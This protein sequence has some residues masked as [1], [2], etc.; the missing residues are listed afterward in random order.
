MVRLDID[1]TLERLV[2]AVQ[3]LVALFDVAQFFFERGDVPILIALQISDLGHMLTP[4]PSAEIWTTGERSISVPLEALGRVMSCD[5][6]R[7]SPVAEKFC[8]RKMTMMMNMSTSGV[9][10]KSVTTDFLPWAPLPKSRLLA[11][12]GE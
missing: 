11:R 3:R 2:R 1:V 6:K 4:V 12:R 9:T 7:I 5:M 8:S 10:S